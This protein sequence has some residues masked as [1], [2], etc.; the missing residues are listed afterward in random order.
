MIRTVLLFCLAAALA[1]PGC[2]Y[3]EKIDGVTVS[4][5]GLTEE[6]DPNYRYAVDG[7]NVFWGVIGL[8]LIAPPIVV[9]TSAWKCPTAPRRG[10][11]VKGAGCVL[12]PPPPCAHF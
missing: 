1:L 2:T 12:P 3:S 10:Q 7:W 8:E 4:C 5:V 6:E 9:L 11:P